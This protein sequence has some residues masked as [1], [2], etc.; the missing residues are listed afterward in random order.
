MS[1][2]VRFDAA[3]VE[4]A[5][6]REHTTRASQIV[7]MIAII[8]PPLGIIAAA[9]S[10]WGIAFSCVDVAVFLMLYVL[11]GLGTTVA[12]LMWMRK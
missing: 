6:V 11:T 8:V 9:V 5:T 7:T 4:I 12:V 1:E 10:L 3:D 2:A